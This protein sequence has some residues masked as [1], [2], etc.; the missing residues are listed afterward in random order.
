M[1]RTFRLARCLMVETSRFCG[2]VSQNGCT[3]E[4]LIRPRIMRTLPWIHRSFADLLCLP[5]SFAPRAL[6]ADDFDFGGVRSDAESPSN[7][8]IL[9]DEHTT[10]F[11]PAG[12]SNAY[13]VFAAANVGALKG[14]VVLQTSDFTN[15]RWH[16]A[17]PA[18]SCRRR[19]RVHLVQSGLRH[20]VRRDYSDPGS[21]LQD[22]TRPPGTLMMF[23]EAETTAPAESRSGLL[24]DDRLCPIDRQRRDVAEAGKRPARRTDRY[25]VLRL[26]TPSRFRACSG[27]HGQ[28]DPAA[29]VDG[30]YVYVTCIAPPGPGLVGDGKQRVARAQLGG[31][32]NSASQS[33]TADRSVSRASVAWITGL[34]RAAASA[35]RAWARSATVDALGLYL[36]TFVQVG[37]R[38][39]PHAACCF[40]LATSLDLQDWTVPQL[41]TNSQYPLYE[42]CRGQHADGGSSMAGIRRSCRRIG[43]RP[44][45]HE[46][47]GFLFSTSAANSAERN[48]T[49]RTCPLRPTPRQS[50]TRACGGTR[51]NPARGINFAH[52]GDQDSP[53]GTPMT[54]AAIRRGSRCSRVAIR[55]AQQVHRRRLRRRRT[56]LQ[57]VSRQGHRHEGRHRRRGVPRRQQDR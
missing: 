11:P 28:R 24:R 57:S 56:D 26:A 16:P 45:R 31:A 46:R 5:R 35:P 34:R 14:T 52:E 29:F 15:S 10:F 51:R 19:C 4:T 2:P 40:S 39:P 55:K 37:H 53:P 32:V 42:P 43:A 7:M 27:A 13:T 48:I 21:V 3:S 49:S 18:R 22:P 6:S 30:N 25:P 38:C 50:T 54:P 12:G 1:C 20:G 9:P 47:V 17:T 36:M 23:Y 8:T 33:G 44:H 41:I